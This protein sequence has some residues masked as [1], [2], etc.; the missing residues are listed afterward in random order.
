L[1]RVPEAGIGVI[2]RRNLQPTVVSLGP[3]RARHDSKLNKISQ[4]GKS[5]AAFGGKTGPSQP[6]AENAVTFDRVGRRPFLQIFFI[7]CSAPTHAD[8]TH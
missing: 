1:K 6:V 5:A 7:A 8:L 4:L 3:K 2:R